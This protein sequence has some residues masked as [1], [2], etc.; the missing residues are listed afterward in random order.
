MYHKY[1]VTIS[2]N[3]FKQ[4]INPQQISKEDLLGFFVL[5]FVN[6]SY[7]FFFNKNC[8]TFSWLIGN[9]LILIPIA[10]NNPL[11]IAGIVG[12][13]TISPTPLAP[14]GPFFDGCSTRNE[15]IFGV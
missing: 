3:Y 12:I 10:L 9:E 7:K 5:V 15:V 11:A 14:N 4:R 6:L 8:K 1:H 13:R 2:K